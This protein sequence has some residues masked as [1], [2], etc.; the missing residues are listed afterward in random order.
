MSQGRASGS[1]H[2]IDRRLAGRYHERLS[3]RVVVPATLPGNE[4]VFAQYVIRSRE[5]DALAR[6][7]AEQGI[8]TQIH[9]ARALHEQPVFS[10]LAARAPEAERAAREVLS[11]PLYPGLTDAQQD[12]VV[13]AVLASR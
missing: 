9:Y 4:H 6:A 12:R 7:M 3:G 11:L 10:H 13:D 1:G 2:E 5:R 8:P